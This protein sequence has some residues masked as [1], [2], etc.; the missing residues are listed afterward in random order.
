MNIPKNTAASGTA[1]LKTNN[2]TGLKTK[3]KIMDSAKK[4]FAERGFL[5]VTVRQIAAH[6][7]VNSALVG[8]YFGSKQALFNEVYRSFARPLAMERIRMLSE[9]DK[10]EKKP[11]VE[12]ILKAWLLPWLR[13]G[14]DPQQTALHVR[15]TAHV[16]SERWKHNKKAAQYTQQAHNTFIE[17]LHGALPHLS[18]KTLTWRLHF[19]VG[20]IAFGIQDPDPLIAF[21][22][23][24]CN[25]SN[26]ESS[27]EQVLPFAIRGFSAPEQ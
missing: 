25:P 20:A 8:Y 24:E 5:H 7:G 18:R 21:S 22:K 27:L 10:A 6:A 2:K 19:I 4:L 16:S 1:S 23:G 15:F 3:N 26:V 12:D 14:D 13:A 9:L 17:A 11:S